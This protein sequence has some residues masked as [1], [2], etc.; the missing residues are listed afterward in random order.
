MSH[1]IFRLRFHAIDPPLV[2]YQPF[3]YPSDRVSKPTLGRLRGKPIRV[4]D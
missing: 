4:V 1:A 3:G 2:R